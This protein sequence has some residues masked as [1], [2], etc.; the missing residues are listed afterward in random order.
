MADA[1]DSL[2]ELTYNLHE[3]LPEDLDRALDEEVDRRRTD[4]YI[5]RLVAGDLTGTEASYRLQLEEQIRLRAQQ[6]LVLVGEPRQLA[7]EDMARL[8][9]RLR[10]LNARPPIDRAALA[11]A[12]EADI[13]HGD[14]Q[15]RLGVINAGNYRSWRNGRFKDDSATAEKIVALLVR[16]LRAQGV[17]VTRFGVR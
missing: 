8:E 11:E 13:G 5:K 1:P 17:D 14:L 12:W 3:M 9:A 6:A 4:E 16:E 15:L 2:V 7:L 10:E